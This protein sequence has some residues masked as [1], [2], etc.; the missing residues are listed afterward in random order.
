MKNSIFVKESI[1]EIVKLVSIKNS[2]FLYSSKINLPEELKINGQKKIFQNVV[3]QLLEKAKSS[4]DEK[5]FNLII[6]IT[7]KIE[8]DHEFSVSVTYSGSGFSFLE[9]ELINRAALLFRENNK[10]FQICS[11]SRIIKHK[12]QAKLKIISEKNKGATIK[13]IFP[14]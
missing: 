5:L 2:R 12:F 9:K 4:Y 10:N 3:L 14:F 8:N 1:D 6:L 13:C 7:A 11:I